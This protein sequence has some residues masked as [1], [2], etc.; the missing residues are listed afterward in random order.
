MEPSRQAWVAAALRA[1]V[2]YFLIG[3]I[4]ALPSDHVQA[5]RLAAWVASGIVFATHIGYEH[6]RLRSSPGQGAL[7]VAVA[8]AVG[9]F[10]LA[11]AGMIHALTTAS[12]IRPTWLLALVAWP[13]FT[14][15]PAFLVALMAGVVMARRS[16]SA[17]PG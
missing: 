17:D 6:Y 14:A 3:R 10:L 12:G 8:V 2:A 5:W 16:R 4:F 7:H 9:A 13:A 15:A 1:G 11:V